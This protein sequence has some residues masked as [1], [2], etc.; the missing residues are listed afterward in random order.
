MYFDKLWGAAPAP[1]LLPSKHYNM[2]SGRRQG[3]PSLSAAREKMA[4]RRRRARLEGGF[5][6]PAKSSEI[7][8]IL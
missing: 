7:P 2:L 6:I 3:F 1:G 4:L 5:P 8:F